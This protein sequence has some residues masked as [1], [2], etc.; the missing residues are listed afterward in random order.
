MCNIL[1][2][3]ICDCTHLSTTYL[4]EEMPFG[5]RL[6]STESKFVKLQEKSQYFDNIKQTSLYEF[7][8]QL[9][10]F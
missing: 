7:S 1:Y 6:V 10:D 3:C 5:L 4:C 9:K 2:I 8:K